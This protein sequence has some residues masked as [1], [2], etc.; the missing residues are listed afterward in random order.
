MSNQDIFQKK[1]NGIIT[2][3][4]KEGTYEDFINLQNNNTCN[5][6]NFFRTTIRRFEK[7]N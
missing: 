4:I 6:Y 1:I 7:K 3:L 2:D 5:A